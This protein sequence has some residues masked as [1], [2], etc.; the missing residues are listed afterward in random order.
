MAHSFI[1]RNYDDIPAPMREILRDFNPA[2]LYS[3]SLQTPSHMPDR[4][5]TLIVN[6]IQHHQQNIP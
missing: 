1:R 2:L 5:V 3:G 6:I 4:M